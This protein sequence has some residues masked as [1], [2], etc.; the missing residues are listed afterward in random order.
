MTGIGARSDQS[1]ASFDFT[2]AR[3]EHTFGKPP[4]GGMS[5]MGGK[6]LGR[7]LIVTVSF[8]GAT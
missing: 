1:S 7:T 2:D 8:G 6:P 5:W 4:G 3:R